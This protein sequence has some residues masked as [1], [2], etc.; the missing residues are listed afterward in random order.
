MPNHYDY[1][2][3]FY[4]RYY[5]PENCVMIV[6]GDFDQAELER[7]TKQYYGAWPRGDF[8]P[9]FPRSAPGA[10]ANG[11]LDLAQQDT[12]ASD[13]RLPRAGVFR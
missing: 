6:V 7:L 3:Q 5:R 1:S 12:S 9:R 4:E 13:D 8:T 2:L 11:C 10:G